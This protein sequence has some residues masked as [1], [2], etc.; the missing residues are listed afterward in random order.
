MTRAQNIAR[1]LSVSRSL[2]L[3]ISSLRSL[4]IAL[5]FGAVVMV[6]KHAQQKNTGAGRV[7]FGTFRSAM[8]KHMDK[9]NHPAPNNSICRS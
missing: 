3:G 7:F 1:A 8:V 4:L 5:P 6:S 9:A 2:P